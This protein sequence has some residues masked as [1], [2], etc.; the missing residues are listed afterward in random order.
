M[1]KI[2]LRTWKKHFRGFKWK[3]NW[4]VVVD[5]SLNSETSMNSMTM[6]VNISEKKNKKKVKNFFL[7]FYFI[8]LLNRKSIDFIMKIGYDERKS[9]LK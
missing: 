5:N 6:P 9:V 2:S 1:Q 3:D 7:F 4:E 8:V